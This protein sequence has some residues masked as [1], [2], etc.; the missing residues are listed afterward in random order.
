MTN[1][2]VSLVV[3]VTL[4]LCFTGCSKA[5]GDEKKPDEQLQDTGGPPPDPPTV[6]AIPTTAM[7]AAVNG[8]EFKSPHVLV[9]EDYGK[10]FVL[11]VID[12]KPEANDPCSFK[13]TKLVGLSTAQQY[14]IGKP[15]ELTG[16]RTTIGGE[17]C[18]GEWYTSPDKVVGAF[19]LD[20]HS[21]AADDKP[22]RIKIRAAVRLVGKAGES[23]TEGWLNGT[24]EGTMCSDIKRI[25]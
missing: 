9:R 21:G 24:Y 2:H 6:A 13:K 23:T 20:A 18:D 10:A 14:E 3:C 19:Q 8:Q 1:I 25:E 11:L 22:G 5:T 7:R 4:P 17:I 12:G 15:Y 16:S